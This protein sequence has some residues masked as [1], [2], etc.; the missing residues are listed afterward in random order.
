MSDIVSGVKNTL[1]G[2]TGNGNYSTFTID[3]SKKCL[4]PNINVT[5]PNKDVVPASL[6]GD[7]Q[8]NSLKNIKL[9]VKE[10]LA[11]SFE[12][13]L[14]VVEQF[15][16]PVREAI[17]TILGK[18]PGYDHVKGKTLGDTAI[19]LYTAISQ[20]AQGTEATTDA[21]TTLNPVAYRNVPYRKSMPDLTFGGRNFTIDFAYGKCNLFNAQ[22]EVYEP[23]MALKNILFPQIS[24]DK[25]FPGL[26]HMVKVN[27]IPFEQQIEL[28]TIGALVNPIGSLAANGEK[29]T[30]TEII[31]DIKTSTS[32]LT[33]LIRDSSNVS[34]KVKALK[35]LVYANAIKVDDSHL[36]GVAGGF[37][38]VGNYA[39]GLLTGNGLTGTT[40]KPL[41]NNVAQFTEAL[42][43]IYKAMGSDEYQV[44][45]PYEEG[46]G[47]DKNTY[48]IPMGSDPDSSYDCQSLAKEALLDLQNYALSTGQRVNKS[49]KFN[50]DGTLSEGDL[51]T[52]S[53]D[54]AK[55]K[56]SILKVLYYVINLPYMIASVVNTDK[57]INV[58]GRNIFFGY[59]PKYEH[60]L[61][62]IATFCTDTTNAKIQLT[63]ILF[64]NYSVDFDYSDIDMNGY[65]M[66]GKLTVS[67]IWNINDPFNTLLLKS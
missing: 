50:K 28:K 6:F 5:L 64:T 16:K 17:N 39:G 9:S 48:K 56:E 44:P 58:G 7:L 41:G 20:F 15:A 47:A 31:K 40:Y 59:R 1:E 21:L 63:N 13:S 53:D 11:S 35:N 38:K 61:K 37:K 12:K 32:S 8:E 22:Y 25:D 42:K 62:D 33:N 67:S 4:I 60:N 65:P 29:K 54:V 18:L 10:D 52:P 2:G 49:V 30:I 45:L 3:T 51:I 26:G 57:D 43:Q 14:D 46:D 23:L 27:P 55:S 19:Y 66:S 34:N 24:P 36:S